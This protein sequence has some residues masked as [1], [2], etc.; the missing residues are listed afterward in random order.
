MKLFKEP[1]MKKKILCLSLISSIIFSSLITA[2]A[3][4]DANLNSADKFFDLKNIFGCFSESPA[5]IVAA[6]ISAALLLMFIVFNKKIK[7]KLHNS[8]TSQLT[9]A[10]IVF[11]SVSGI[12]CLAMAFATDGETW[13][14]LMHTNS[15]LNTYFV[16]FEDYINGIRSSGSQNFQQTA[17]INTP[18]THL[19]YFIL[20]QFLPPKLIFSESILEYTKIL[21]DQTF[22]F[23]YLLLITFCIVILYRMNRTV[24]RNNK[25]HMRDE[26]VAFLLVVSYPT[27]FCIEKGNIA[28][29]SL[30]LVMIF[31]LFR[32]AE[33]NLIKELSYIALAAA[34]AITPYTL[35]FALL[36]F[37]EKNKKCAMRFARTV[38]YFLIMFI[39]P[40]VFTGFGN[41]LTYLNS[42]VSVAGESFVAGNMSIANLLHFFGIHNTVVVYAVVILTELIAGLALITLP[43]TWQKSAAAVYIILNI[44]AVSD[45]VAVM[46]VF[47]PF[48]FL[49]AEKEHNPANWL[50]L[51]AF[52]LLITPFPE[53]FR[54]DTNFSAFLSAMGISDIQNANNLISLAATQFILVI[55]FYQI[56]S[57]MKSKKAEKQ[58]K[59][60]EQITN[61]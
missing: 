43:S 42:F 6:I 24:L 15:S 53:W 29:F 21:K 30:V 22:M 33:K 46:F 41:L 11:F 35:I 44:Y 5:A 20:A 59:N 50:Y 40:A 54:Y 47:I 51:L 48:I 14:N 45:A 56:I 4:S 55:L 52:T 13:S 3:E 25:L 38:L 57:M 1:E 16:Q 61:I 37:E 9:N 27:V 12:A 34:S 19:I 8:T 26:V 7:G 23:L 28:I 17:E 31:M 39:S 32:D 10:F 49:L 2:F 36:L 58:V 18:F 60:T